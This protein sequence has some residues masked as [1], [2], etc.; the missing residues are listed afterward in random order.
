[1][2]TRKMR[3]MW[4][5]LQNEIKDYFFNWSGTE[6]GF[7]RL[8][9]W[10]RLAALLGLTLRFGFNQNNYADNSFLLAIIRVA[11][12]GYFFFN[13]VFNLYLVDFQTRYSDSTNSKIVQILV[14]TLMLAFFYLVSDDTRSDVFLMYFLPLL[15]IARYLG[16][17]AIAWF[18]VFTGLATII[19][20]LIVASRSDLVR[21]EYWIQVLLPRLGFLAILTVFYL[22]YYR[23]RRMVGHLVSEEGSLLVGFKSLTVGAFSVD[24]HLRLV[25]MNEAMSQRHG[26]GLIGSACHHALCK[27]TA[28]PTRP[29]QDC[30]LAAAVERGETMSNSR[31]QF[32]DRS[33]LLY[34]AHVSALPVFNA[35]REIVGVAAIV[36]DLSEQ[37]LFEQRL[38]S[39]AISVERTVDTLTQESR[40]RVEDM[41]RQLTTISK[42]S[43]AAL[44]PNQ[45]LGIDEIVR[46]A[47]NLLRC[48]AADVRQ[49]D[50]DEKTGRQGLLLLDAFGYTPEEAARKYFLDIHFP[51]V[52]VEA[53]HS[54]ETRCIEDVQARPGLVQ[55]METPRKYNLHTMAS[56]PLVARGNKIGT[57]S[58][59]RNR[60]QMFSPEEMGLGQAL[61]NSLAT[62][63]FNQNLL[64]RISAEVTTRQKSLD[65]LSK[66]SRE[67]APQGNIQSLAQLVSDLVRGELN[68]ESSA[69]FL[70]EGDTLHRAAIS[71]LEPDWFAEECYR[72][73]QGITGQVVQMIEGERYGRPKIENAVDESTIVVQTNLVR[74]SQKLPSRTVRHLLA[75]PLNGHERTF[76]VLRV[77]NKLKGQG[78]LDPVG[79]NDR[80]VDLMSTIACIVAVAI[81]NARRLNENIHLFEVEQK[82]RQLTETL[83][84]TMQ[85]LSSTLDLDQTLNNILGHLKSVVNYNTA[86]LFLR[87]GD[88]LLLRAQA[89]FPEEE[90]AVLE[91][92]SLDVKANIPFQKIEASHRPFIIADAHQEPVLDQ[93]AGTSQIRSWIGAPLLFND[94]VIGQLSV[95]NWE[96]NQYDENHALLVMAFAQQAAIA[97]TNANLFAQQRKLN[98]SFVEVTKV[99]SLEE[100]VDKVAQCV[101]ELMC[102]DISGVALYDEDKEEISTMPSFGYRGVSENLA[103]Q[104]R[105]NINHPHAEIIR[106]RRVFSTVDAQLEPNPIFS[107]RWAK[108]VG[109]RGIIAAPL[110]VGD[111]PVGIL[112]AASKSARQ[113]SEDEQAIFFSFANQVTAVIRS[114][115]L[116]DQVERRYQL[117]VLFH[118]I[119]ISGQRTS[120]L[121]RILN[122]VLTGV[123]AEYGLLFNRAMLFLMDESRENLVGH[124]GIGQIE[125]REAQA[126]WEH[127]K[128]EAHSFDGYV[129]EV[130]EHGVPEWT[131]L[132]HLA[133][134]LRVPIK[135]D[136]LE[137][138]SRVI[139][140]QQ[141]MVVDPAD[142]ESLIDTDFYRL[143]EPAKFVLVPLMNM[144]GRVIGVL[145]ADNKFTGAPITQTDIE[146]LEA[147]TSQAAAAVERARLQQDSQ[148]RIGVLHHLQEVSKHI[149]DLTDLRDVLQRIVKAANDVLRADISYLAPYNSGAK[150][151]MVD[152]AVSVGEHGDF[153]H[154]RKFS[155][156]GLT[157]RVLYETSSLIVVDDL[158]LHPG[159]ESQF[160]ESEGVRSVAVVRLESHN[161]IVG[162]LYVNYRQHHLFTD[163]DQATLH[164]FADQAAIA[165][166]NARLMEQNE[167]LVTRRER[168]RLRE[169]LHDALNTLRFKVMLP[170]EDTRDRMQKLGNIETAEELRRLWYSASHTYQHF[171]RILQD[172]RNP[173]LVDRGL[174]EAIRSSIPDFPGFR[175]KFSVSEEIRL[176][177]DVELALFRIF[178]EALSNISKHADLGEEEPVDINLT[179]T[180]SLAHMVIQDY[181]R[182]FSRKATIRE[183][184]GIGLQAMEN[185]ARKVSAE[186]SIDS[187][188]GKG[189][190]ISVLV[191]LVEATI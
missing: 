145:A 46:A 13:V 167:L 2:L 43:V 189:T 53:F 67:L 76:G 126:I 47:A 102:C 111:R 157:T 106:S 36:K 84:Q 39:Y 48:Q 26:I 69:I 105:F 7:L 93:I 63:I 175:I 40:A 156:T 17:R 42:A 4:R 103:R 22:I 24:H 44:S 171:L 148:R 16:L 85:T 31:V 141:S 55:F 94:Q 77:V 75:V 23:R 129:R 144:D 104:F 3:S 165:I 114:A 137:V 5:N 160:A 10:F 133:K 122:I 41:T 181:G 134:N 184:R 188:P 125:K 35:A 112:Y 91:K 163:Q 119:S 99:R 153:E 90:S 33:G 89:G 124:T 190:R 59:Y 30:P 158:T 81:E 170:V 74:Y 146:L 159:L 52:V 135:T 65:A 18:L 113:F 56:F 136:S 174:I 180:P 32:A 96:P 108:A 37:A 11:L 115:E 139:V 34:S 154:A 178:Q 20:W 61:A 150:E 66:F 120:D 101:V 29:C 54:G 179:L 140:S 116:R 9:G 88:K 64:D 92:A 182:G 68:A 58:L 117:Q 147:C 57:L 6:I 72:V 100:R 151:L 107:S 80:D 78:Q 132:H 38:Q 177:A 138:F 149:S 185:W 131:T 121:D 191:P 173:M 14:D 25:A 118:Q 142:G 83:L 12:W 21:L 95:D 15:I 82:R 49:L 161:E 28:D 62:A 1:M 109:A 168:D 110:A 87:Q 70:L 143:F 187:S 73:G 79:F 97:I 152:L 130:L 164:M 128:P 186:I 86:S 166:R 169:D 8:V 51:S 162:V 176:S 155:N 27:S 98:Q 45:P 172:M 123:T 127:L 60:R 71:G 19:T 50:I 183:G